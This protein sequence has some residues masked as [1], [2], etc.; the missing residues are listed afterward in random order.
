[1]A[2]GNPIN[3]ISFERLRQRL[4][5]CAPT[6]IE[7]VLAGTVCGKLVSGPAPF[8]ALGYIDNCDD[9]YDVVDVVLNPMAFG[10]GLK[11]KSVEAIFEGKPLIATTTA[12]VGLPIMHRL[13]NLASPEEVADLVAEFDPRELPGLADASRQCAA[14]YATGVYAA[15][16]ALVASMNGC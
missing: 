5:H 2:S 14:A 15:C 16:R 6:Q 9:F 3:V 1:L 4:V 8:R 10:T 7:F 12:M 13:H 11:I